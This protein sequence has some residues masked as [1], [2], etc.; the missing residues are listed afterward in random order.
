MIV[1]KVPAISSEAERRYD[2]LARIVGRSTHLAAVDPAARD[3]QPGDRR[4]APDP[5]LRRPVADV[6][7][8]FDQLWAKLRKAP[9]S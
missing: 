1:N 5:L 4:T 3:R 9:R 6:T 8:A 2:E 7:D